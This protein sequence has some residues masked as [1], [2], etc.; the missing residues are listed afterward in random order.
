M[1]LGGM[2]L[3]RP[4][5]SDEEH[6]EQVGTPSAI[7][8]LGLDALASSSYGPEAALTVLIG[9]GAAASLHLTPIIG[10]V[11]L[12]L[13]ATA[14]SYRQTIPAYPRGGGSF[15][16]AKDNLGPRAGLVAAS[17]L[18][19]DYVLNVA[20]AISAGVG[21]LV[22]AVPPLLPYTL[23]LCLGLLA[24]LTL[25]NL[26]GARSAGLL[27]MVPT[28]LFVG[29]LLATFVIGGVRALAAGGD[30]VPAVAPPAPAPVTQAATLWLLAHAFAAGCTALTGIEAVSNA[31]P[32]FR[33]PTI[34]RAVRTLTVLVALLAVLL[35]GVALLTRAFHVVPTVPGAPG[36]QSVISQIVGAV[37]GRGAF[38]YVTMAAVLAVLALSANTSFAGFPR[39]LRVLAED[40]YLPA[41]FA[42]RGRR[43]VYGQ[44][45][46]LLAALSAALLIGF[47]GITDRLIPLFAVGA[48]GAFTMSQIGMVAHWRRT[49]GPHARRSRILNATGATATG[50]TLVVI[51]VAKF[52]EGAWLTITVIPALVLTFTHIRRHHDRLERASQGEGPLDLGELD[53][54]P[55]IVIPMR[56]LGQAARKALRVAYLMSSDVRAVQILAEE[57]ATDDLTEMWPG[58]VQHPTR[59]AGRRAPTLVVIRSPYRE[60]FAP[61]LRYVRRLAAEHPGRVIAVL[62]PE[63]VQRG[64]AYFLARRRSRILKTL[65]LRGG[66][67]QIAIVDIPWYVDAPRG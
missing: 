45:I 41:G 1:G 36:Y 44:G 40:E 59:A 34:P 26:R 20:V 62:V 33:P 35:V 19:V 52:W 5:R 11:L 66:G 57:M 7:P 22:S 48:F 53:G 65:L 25:V 30:P 49:G 55:I 12:V 47:G 14:L 21:A 56:R 8:V 10:L 46:L 15:T 27:L 4:L 17:M 37:T 2:L 42:H 63:E 67:P 24:L 3:G 58:L 51:V 29:C 28:Y 61:F 13:L 16:V 9:L 38:Y 31:V 60:F 43:L 54:D 50:A 6:V 23:P 32:I 39:V 18:V 64:W